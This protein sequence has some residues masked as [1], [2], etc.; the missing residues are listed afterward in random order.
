MRLCNLGFTTWESASVDKGN[1]YVNTM[2]C[3]FCI[4]VCIHCIFCYSQFNHVEK[5]CTKNG[6]SKAEFATYNACQL[7]NNASRM[8]ITT[9]TNVVAEKCK[10]TIV[11]VNIKIHRF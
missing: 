6:L 9:T 4:C 5:W 8:M 10:S 1:R 2:N 3:F 7:P 11:A